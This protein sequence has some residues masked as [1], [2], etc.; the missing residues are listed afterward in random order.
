MM[1]DLLLSHRTFP[2]EVLDS[3]A[4]QQL[5]D[6]HDAGVD[7]TNALWTLLALQLWAD[8]HLRPLRVAR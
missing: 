3:A 7:H 8:R 5:V 4:L 1:H 2:N 6:E